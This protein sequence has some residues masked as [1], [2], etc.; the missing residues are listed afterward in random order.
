MARSGIDIRPWKNPLA[1]LGFCC[2]TWFIGPNEYAGIAGLDLGAHGIPTMDDFVARYE[3]MTRP[4]GRLKL[5]HVVFAL[6]RFS[7][8]FVGIADRARAGT[9]ADAGAAATGRL[10]SNFAK[11]ALEVATSDGAHP[12]Y[13]IRTNTLSREKPLEETTMPKISSLMPRALVAAL[14]VTSVLASAAWAQNPPPVR[15]RGTMESVDGATM[16]I[17][18]RDGI[19]MKV[20]M[21]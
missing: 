3:R 19:D 14:T 12:A 7:V 2:M 10:A 5:F 6:F 1:D 17:E 8:I 20:R 21:F 13:P 16:M 9:A 18:S 11:R 4:S 15:I